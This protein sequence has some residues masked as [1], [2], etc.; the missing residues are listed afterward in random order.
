L[1]VCA[2]LRFVCTAATVVDVMAWYP[3]CRLGA[4][5][6]PLFQELLPVL[7][8]AAHDHCGADVREGV[9][10]LL[11]DA[12]D[13][14]AWSHADRD[15]CCAVARHGS[16]GVVPVADVS[17]HASTL[18]PMHALRAAW[19]AAAWGPCLT[20]VTLLP[21]AQR[22][23]LSPS[24]L[25]GAALLL[26]PELPRA[27]YV[28]VARKNALVQDYSWRKLVPWPALEAVARGRDGEMTPGPAPAPA[29][30]PLLDIVAQYIQTAQFDAVFKPVGKGGYGAVWHAVWH[31]DT[32]DVH[33]AVKVSLAKADGDANASTLRQREV[34][35]LTVVRAHPN[36]VRILGVCAAPNVIVLEYIDAQDDKAT[37]RDWCRAAEYPNVP[38]SV[39]VDIGAQL[40]AGLGHV[41]ACGVLHRDVKPSNVLMARDA[42]RASGWR[43]RVSDFG[44]SAFLERAATG[45]L[46]NVTEHACGTHG[47]QAPEQVFP[48]RLCGGSIARVRRDDSGGRTFTLTPKSDVFSFGVVL[49]RLFCGGDNGS[50]SVVV[51]ESAWDHIASSAHG[52]LPS[53]TYTLDLLSPALP[54]AA[55][56]RN[57]L[58]F[59]KAA[60]ARQLPTLAFVLAE[61]CLRP[62]ADERPSFAQLAGVFELE[63][64]QPDKWLVPFDEDVDDDADVDDDVANPCDGDDGG[65]GR[66]AFA[67]AVW[68]RAQA[69]RA[70]YSGLPRAVVVQAV[71]HADADVTDGDRDAIG[72]LVDP[73]GNDV[74]TF[75]GLCR[76]LRG[77]ADAAA[78]R[79]KA[80]RP[81]FAVPP[82]PTTPFLAH[83]RDV[84]LVTEQL[85]K[86][87]RDANT[88]A[89]WDPDTPERQLEDEPVQ[90]TIAEAAASDDDD[91]DDDDGAD[92]DSKSPKL[93]AGCSERVFAI[94]GAPG[95]GKSRFLLEAVHAA[96][97]ANPTLFAG[98]T[99]FASLDDVALTPASLF[100]AVCG[101]IG[102]APTGDSL[103]L[104]VQRW[105]TRQSLRGNV[106]IAVDGG[107][108]DV[109]YVASL[110]HELLFESYDGVWDT[111]NPNGARKLHMRPNRV[112]C[113][114]AG[115]GEQPRVLTALAAAPRVLHT[116][117]GL[118]RTDAACLAQRLAGCTELPVVADAQYVSP[119]LVHLCCGAVLRSQRFTSLPE[120]SWSRAL[121]HALWRQ[122]DPMER[123]VLARLSAC[124]APFDVHVAQVLCANA[125]E[126]PGTMRGLASKGVLL[127]FA[128]ADAASSAG[129]CTWLVPAFVSTVVL[130]RRRGAA[131]GTVPTAFVP[132]GNDVAPPPANVLEPLLDAAV[133]DAA[134]AAF[135]HC[136]AG[137]LGASARVYQSTTAIAGALA[138]FDRHRAALLQLLDLARTAM[139]QPHAVRTA[140][141]YILTPGLSLM[142]V[143]EMRVRTWELVELC[144]SLWLC[145]WSM[146][147]SSH[148]ARRLGVA[149]LCLSRALYLMDGG[150]DSVAAAD[151]GLNLIQR[152]TARSMRLDGGGVDG[153][154]HTRRAMPRRMARDG[155]LVADAL[156]ALANVLSEDKRAEAALN[157]GVKVEYER[158]LLYA[159]ERLA[160]MKRAFNDVELQALALTSDVFLHLPA[161]WK[162][163]SELAKVL[164]PSV[165]AAPPSDRV[166]L[167]PVAALPLPSTVSDRVSGTEGTAAFAFASLDRVPLPGIP[168]VRGSDGETWE[169]AKSDPVKRIDRALLL[170]CQCLLTR[171][172]YV[173]TR[174]RDYASAWY[175]IGNTLADRGL[176]YVALVA[177]KRSRM[178]DEAVLCPD[179]PA[180]ARTVSSAAAVWHDLGKHDEALAQY[181]ACLAMRERVLGSRHL[182]VARTLSYMGI[183][184]HAQG[185][186]WTALHEFEQCYRI[187]SEQLGVHPD[188]AATLNNRAIV[189]NKL[190]TLVTREEDEPVP[191]PVLGL[192]DVQQA[193][194]RCLAIRRATLG[195]I[196]PDVA[197]SLDN[198]AVVCFKLD[199]RV[200]AVREL[201]KCMYVQQKLGRVLDVAKSKFKQGVMQIKDDEDKAFEN[202]QSCLETRRK[203][204]GPLHADVRAT[205]RDVTAVFHLQMA[206][207]ESSLMRR[208]MW[209]DM[210]MQML[211]DMAAALRD[212]SFQASASAP[213]QGMPVYRYVVDAAEMHPPRGVG[214][215]S[216]GAGAGAG[217]G[218]ASA[219]AA[220]QLPL[221]DAD[222][223]TNMAGI[224]ATL[225]TLLDGCSAHAPYL[226][227]VASRCTLQSVAV[228]ELQVRHEKL[229]SRMAKDLG[230]ARIN[231]G[232]VFLRRGAYE[233]AA[234]EFN[235]AVELL[236][237]I[238]H[239]A[240][241]MY[242]DALL[243]SA[244][245]VVRTDPVRSFGF[246][247]AARALCTQDVL[248]KA[249]QRRF[250]LLANKLQLY[251]DVEASWLVREDVAALAV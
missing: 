231:A 200:C 227:D 52:S 189:V 55:R 42:A 195:H 150:D 15:A 225:V 91:D 221:V 13:G 218:A 158:L 45:E 160:V 24:E 95:T 186:F 9:P 97:A 27:D 177:Y 207:R 240:N 154:A 93:P 183:V 71:L 245:A 110:L 232:A 69:S 247:K 7:R 14:V 184:R 31:A 11:G 65:G 40:C 230:S 179:H 217:A 138:V 171:M 34:D 181:Q 169:P 46:V 241:A 223:A 219:A 229:D 3:A 100:T 16:V 251:D 78:A 238:A 120:S 56:M 79:A 176:K 224:G 103:S 136:F 121:V 113:I 68:Q 76:A 137:V 67:V 101:V 170:Y 116:L 117:Y 243:G 73:I 19:D 228:A 122:L 82:L 190:V 99:V 215:T 60:R 168:P 6:F 36:V 151:Y 5:S 111:L 62:R 70:V 25:G 220:P 23:L 244:E 182:D 130:E 104:D 50:S 141:L 155:A 196:H 4:A 191:K 133:V 118:T 165:M 199:D 75:A 134:T 92:D 235:L 185:K 29:P 139:H 54:I 163:N 212:K 157:A 162:Q 237:P 193:Y 84:H 248:R 1:T 147:R 39:L 239:A 47:Y 213:R 43:A 159:S 233:D 12:A 38:Y 33:V 172:L 53:V 127:E 30:A 107:T 126:L 236:R 63:Q 144:S 167:G 211:S 88:T 194:E 10:L 148:N 109:R 198:L 49:F 125:A 208:G 85:A 214:S 249:M 152:V 216:P 129:S 20:G 175:N 188:V 18:T 90:S 72:A 105:C 156:G 83:H 2:A 149:S 131:D 205:L 178:V 242:V 64:A 59:A 173:G 192:K 246:A 81:L 124:R 112:F 26:T 96:H 41:H 58:L 123:A 132:L 161:L 140:L 86:H 61:W 80:Q 32:G 250:V 28:M 164:G 203:E 206:K 35:V 226:L 210:Q 44:I 48:A 234:W 102:L 209:L 142:D 222:V 51:A 87:V 197:H 22:R 146:P 202:F 106:L 180:I 174:S 21:E 166:P 143:L 201:D 98:G 94:V 77:C 108:S 37:L 74:V 119:R 114:I 57:S 204:G 89:R 128:D 115:S 17:T 66:D 145:A 187:R 8:Q 135:V 153:A